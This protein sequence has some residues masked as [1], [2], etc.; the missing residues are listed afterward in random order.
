MFHLNRN[1][2]DHLTDEELLNSYLKSH[3]LEI[4]G[5]LYKRYAHLVY[6]VCLKYL[7][8]RDDGKDAAMQIFEKIINELREKDVTNFK[9]WIYVVTKKTIALCNYV[10]RNIMKIRMLS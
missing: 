4:I 6:G 2:K 3:D 7:K 8:D 10:K 9:S 5:I 1:Q